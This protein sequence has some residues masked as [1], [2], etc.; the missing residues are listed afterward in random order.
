MNEFK[1][2]F[3]L[4]SE[5]FVLNS[6]YIPSDDSDLLV[7]SVEI[8]KNSS[9]LD[10]GCGSGIQGLNALFKGAKKTVFS[11]INPKALKSAEKN[12][13]NAG[14]INSSEFIESN[15]F[16]NINQKFD[17]IIF[18]PP[19]VLSEE[20]KFKE[21][22]GGINGRIVL[23]KFL[24]EFDLYLNEKGMIFF[25]QSNLNDL[26]ETKKILELKGFNYEIIARKKLFFE[27]LIV[28]KAFRI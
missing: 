23:N 12:V 6:V 22:D 13:L 5:Q 28:I 11:D 16:S 2:T 19:Y 21:L 27:E 4:N 26:N 9:V 25:L 20:I 14:L 7:N 24:N 1:K 10:L 15:L 8:N 17:V 18:N 3:F